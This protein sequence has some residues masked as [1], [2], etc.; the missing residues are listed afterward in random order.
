MV[1]CLLSHV[2]E[3]NKAHRQRPINNYNN[4]YIRNKFHSQAHSACSMETSLLCTVNILHQLFSTS[5]G[6]IKI[7]FKSLHF[8]GKQ[9]FN[10]SNPPVA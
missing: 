3:Q 1:L 8:L 9:I 10:V 7:V 2:I 6:F 4:H 5:E